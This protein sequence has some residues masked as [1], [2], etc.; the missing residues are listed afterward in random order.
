MHIQSYQIRPFVFVALALTLVVS[1]PMRFA[2]YPL[3]YDYPFHLA[4]LLVLTEFFGGGLKILRDQFPYQESWDNRRQERQD[5][6]ENPTHRGA[7]MLVQ[8]R[9]TG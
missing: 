9:R 3:L 1:L 7:K 4:R 8:A 2:P 5:A 6:I